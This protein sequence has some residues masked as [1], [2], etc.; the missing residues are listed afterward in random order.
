[1]NIEIPQKLWILML[2]LTAILAMGIAFD[3]AGLC[4]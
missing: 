4:K 3:I 1:M 2:I